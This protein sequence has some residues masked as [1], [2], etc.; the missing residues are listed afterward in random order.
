MV[1]STNFDAE[2]VLA[3]TVTVAVP[4]LD[5]E[6]HLR[7]TLASVAA[8]TYRNIV[9]VLVVDGGSRDG[10]RA[11]AM[12]QPGLPVRVLD[13][14]GRVQSAGLN[15]A[16]REARGTIF[17]RVDGHCVLE[18]DYVQRCVDA[19][20]V[21]GVALVGGGMTPDAEGRV[22][23]G[24]A[25]AMGSRFGAGPARFHT[26]GPPGWVD[27]VYLGAFP[28]ELGRSV[29]GYAEDVGVNEDAELAIRLGRVGGV[30]YDPTIRSRYTPRSDLAAV[31]RQ[32]YRYGHSRALTVRR[33]PRSIRSRQLA[34]PALLLALASP[35]RKEVLSVYVAGV[36]VRTAIETNGERAS[37]PTFAAALPTMHLAWGAGFLA[38]LVYQKTRPPLWC[39]RA[40][41]P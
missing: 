40:S 25:L 2:S 17:V 29:G 14:E 22:H 34:A 5:E 18:P 1:T 12:S 31:A 26:G 27:T 16:L 7:A 32:F 9:E 21:R 19:L 11:I 39:S 41:V 38:G 20:A 23:R 35:W 6:Q 33:H 28:T 36:L 8:Q 13:N 15:V 24:I 10:T 37:A 3:P 4:V 30:W